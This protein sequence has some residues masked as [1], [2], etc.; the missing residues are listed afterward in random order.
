MA[1]FW[2]YVG[3]LLGYGKKKQDLKSQRLSLSDQDAFSVPPDHVAW[4][5]YQFPE[6]GDLH[7]VVE[8]MGDPPVRVEMVDERNLAR[9]QAGQDYEY[10]FDRT[11]TD[12]AE[13]ETYLPPNDYRLLL[14]NEFR[15][16]TADGYMELAF[17]GG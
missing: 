7:L 15:G 9:L 2:E 11:V 8:S 12:E 14:H 4:Y 1:S 13:I 3:F 10:R 6:G 5:D 17:A 16:D